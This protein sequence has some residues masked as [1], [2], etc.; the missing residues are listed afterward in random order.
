MLRE[1]DQ[2]SSIQSTI[3]YRLGPDVD[4]SSFWCC[5]SRNDAAGK[6]FSIVF[7]I[8]GGR[9]ISVT[10]VTGDYLCYKEPKT[11]Y[12]FYLILIFNEVF[13]FKTMS[14]SPGELSEELVT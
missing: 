11:P 9:E 13:N 4:L 14:G 12:N 10:I 1:G 8:Q 6:D 2:T 3:R 5:K 7:N